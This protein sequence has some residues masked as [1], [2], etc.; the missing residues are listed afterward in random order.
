MNSSP[1]TYALIFNLKNKISSQVGSLGLLSLEPAN[2]IYIGS[3]FG[4]GG[5]KARTNRHIKIN[6]VSRWHI[7]YM[8]PFLIL[9]E[10]WHIYNYKC[11]C[12]WAQIF[13]LKGI[14]PFKGFGSS[15]CNCKSH[16]FKFNKKPNIN[17]LR[18]NSIENILI[19]KIN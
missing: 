19:E 16:F 15:D 10:I 3:A 2:Y 4:P 14:V 13:S 1:G 18:A 9:N 6:K 17:L 7:D 11:E 12:V 5:I 8:R